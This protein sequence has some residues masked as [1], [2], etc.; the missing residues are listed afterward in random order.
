M[1]LTKIDQI[2]YVRSLTGWGLVE[3]KEL[4]DAFMAFFSADYEID[5]NP[6]YLIRLSLAVK[7][8]EKGEWMMEDGKLVKQ[9]PL[10]YDDLYNLTSIFKYDIDEKE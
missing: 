6:S 7:K 5:F 1:K 10:E 4:V 9:S 3:S 2:K 8:L